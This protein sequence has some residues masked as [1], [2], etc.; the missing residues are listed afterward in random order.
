[1]LLPGCIVYSSWQRPFYYWNT[2]GGL[3]LRSKQGSAHSVPI[4]PAFC[5]KPGVWLS[6]QQ[7]IRNISDRFICKKLKKRTVHS[8]YMASLENPMPFKLRKQFCFFLLN[9]HSRFISLSSFQTRFFPTVV[10]LACRRD[11]CACLKGQVLS[12]LRRCWGYQ[13]VTCNRRLRWHN[14]NHLKRKTNKICSVYIIWHINQLY[15]FYLFVVSV[16]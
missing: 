6:W 10:L 13:V 15:R 1:M 2:T 9:S 4:V 7:C 16:C 3:V 12:G 14:L 5:N 8:R 11:Y